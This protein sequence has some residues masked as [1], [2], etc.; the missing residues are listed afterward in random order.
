[1]SHNSFREI[2]LRLSHSQICF[3]ITVSRQL[4]SVSIGTS[5]T[6]RDKL[7]GVLLLRSSRLVVVVAVCCL[8]SHTII[9]IPLL[10][11]YI[12]AHVDRFPVLVE[13]IIAELI[14]VVAWNLLWFLKKLSLVL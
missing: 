8:R 6:V 9:I 13:I 14:V 2:I 11:D 3:V 5:L 4:I 10:V 7:D 12:F 1:M